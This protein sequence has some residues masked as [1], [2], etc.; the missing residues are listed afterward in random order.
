MKI[1]IIGTGGR[2]H[3]L[4]HTFCTQGHAIYCLQGNPGLEA[5]ATEVFQGAADN[6]DALVSFAKHH[7][8]DLTVVGPESYLAKGIADFFQQRNLTLFGPTQQASI[9]EASKCWAKQFASRHHIPTARYEISHSLQEANTIARAKITKWNGIVIKPDGLT[10]GKGVTICQTL[11]EAELAIASTMGKNNAGL[12]SSKLVLEERLE[13][14]ELSILAFCDGTH[15]LAMVPAQ[16]YKRLYNYDRGPNT[17]GMGAYA[18]VTITEALQ[19]EIQDDIINKTLSGLLAEKILYRGMI[20]FG[21]M[22]TPAGP[23]LL[24]Y[25]CRLGDPETQVLLPLLQS[26]L[27]DLMLACCHGTLSKHTLAWHENHACCV[28]M[29]S[30]EYPDICERNVPIHGMETLQTRSHQRIF[31]AGTQKDEHGHLYT[32]GGRVLSVVGIGST[33]EEAGTRAY[34]AVSQ[35]SFAGAHYRTDITRRSLTLCSS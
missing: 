8:I 15:L 18:P 7:H 32:K 31:H 14:P 28:V 17:G 3:A 9:L 27:A 16:D 20:Y 22:L 26:D 2:E 1:F 25:N 11:Q 13:G 29:A 21:L 12:S 10:G 5:L 23:K 24:E 35:L 6:F 4:A 19:Q 30:K 34:V 33:L